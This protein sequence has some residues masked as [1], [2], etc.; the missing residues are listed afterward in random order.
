VSEN[1]YR[2]EDLGFVAPVERVSSSHLPVRP[3]APR[4][5]SSAPSLGWLPPQ[6]ATRITR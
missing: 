5:K 4:P 6:V 2:R 1:A 3:T